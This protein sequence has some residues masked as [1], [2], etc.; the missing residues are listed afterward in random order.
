MTDVDFVEEAV[1]EIPE[2]KIDVLRRIDAATKPG[3]IVGTNT[4]TIPVS[5]VYGIATPPDS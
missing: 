1:P 5:V 3:T 2:I 4:S